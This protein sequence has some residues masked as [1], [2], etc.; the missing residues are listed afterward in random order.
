MPV[1]GDISEVC[2]RIV[3]CRVQL[4]NVSF[5]WQLKN[6]TSHPRGFF[7]SNYLLE[8][9][10]RLF[11]FFFFFFFLLILFYFSHWW[12]KN[13]KIIF[14][15]ALFTSVWCVSFRVVQ[16]KMVNVEYFVANIL[17][18]DTNSAL[19]QYDLWHNS[20]YNQNIQKFWMK[21]RPP[22]CLR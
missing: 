13:G 18:S 8:E 11:F 6:F 1:V 16:T 5:S 15:W 9:S 14:Y 19:V 4:L 3:F 12:K 17:I 2:A 20:Q 22:Y 10:W 7:S 21:M